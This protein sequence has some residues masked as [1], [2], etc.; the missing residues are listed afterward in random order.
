MK[1]G[2]QDLEKRLIG[3]RWKINFYEAKRQKLSGMPGL[4][5]QW[6]DANKRLQELWAEFREI[7][8]R[9]GNKH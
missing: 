5:E 7:Y 8:C 6:E 2:K 1:I 3:I 4:E 9:L